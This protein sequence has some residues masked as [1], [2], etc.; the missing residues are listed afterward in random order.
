M[1]KPLFIAAQLTFLGF[2]LAVYGA[3]VVPGHPLQSYRNML[4]I[5]M[6]LVWGMLVLLWFW[7]PDRFRAGLPI[8]SA[9]MIGQGLMWSPAVLATLYLAEAGALLLLWLG[10]VMRSFGRKQERHDSFPA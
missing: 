4:G 5:G 10:F 1:A 7:V 2:G 6:A 9:A 3:T 8:A